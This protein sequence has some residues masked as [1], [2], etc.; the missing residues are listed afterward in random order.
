MRHYR[1]DEDASFTVLPSDKEWKTA[2]SF[3]PEDLLAVMNELRHAFP[4]DTFLNL[5]ENEEVEE[6]DEWDHFDD[7]DE[8]ESHDFPYF[9]LFGQPPINGENESVKTVQVELGEDNI[10][11]SITIDK[12]CNNYQLTI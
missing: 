2:R 10:L 4:S 1:P 8:G 5:E 11:A 6:G 9:G 7:L 3:S 12:A